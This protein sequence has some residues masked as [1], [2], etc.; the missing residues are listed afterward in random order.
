MRIETNRP[1]P[2]KSNTKKYQSSDRSSIFTLPDNTSSPK[3]IEQTETAKETLGVETLLLLQGDISASEQQFNNPLHI[4]IEKAD[5]KLEA[6]DTLAKQLI[7]GRITAETQQKLT[8]LSQD[9]NLLTHSDGMQEVLNQI[10]LR[11]HVELA[12]MQRN[13]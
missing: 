9:V 5:E 8:Q 3:T 2:I 11:I 13:Q 12:K 6:L 1:T 4:A 7:D 10:D